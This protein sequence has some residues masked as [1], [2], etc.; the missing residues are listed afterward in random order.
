MTGVV[1]DTHAFVWYF[2]DPGRLSKTAR[3]AFDQA[4]AK[5][6]QI[7]IPAIVL[8]EICYLVDKGKWRPEDLD[9]LV[10]ALNDAN[11]G[12]VIAPLDQQTALSVR[13]V[14]R[15]IVP[16]MPDRIIAATALSLG[17]PLITRD[18]KIRAS[19]VVTIW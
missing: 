14:D 11:S 15:S 9:T 13:N 18:G 2:L 19:N 5:G 8:V 7:F 12:F 3:D 17:L 1:V 10:A 6:D 16:D 4:A